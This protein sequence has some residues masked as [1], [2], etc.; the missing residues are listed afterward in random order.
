MER[1]EVINAISSE[2]LRLLLLSP[3]V[4]EDDKLERVHGRPTR[5]KQDLESWGDQRA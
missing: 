3:T 2:L 1:E 5:V 4:K